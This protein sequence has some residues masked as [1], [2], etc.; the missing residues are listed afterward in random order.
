MP[1]LKN[2]KKALRSSKR[3]NAV[4]TIIKSQLKTAVD[5]SKK[6][7]TKETVATAYSRIDKAVKKGV[8]HRNAAA[9][10]KSQVG[11]KKVA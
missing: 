7:A 6:S 11:K 1:I 5:T 10:L 4:N 8:I 3:K 2:A 9:R